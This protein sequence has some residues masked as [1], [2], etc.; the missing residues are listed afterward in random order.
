MATDKYEVI[1][2]LCGDPVKD[3]EYGTLWQEWGT[4]Q[5]GNNPIARPALYV[6]CIRCMIDM[7]GG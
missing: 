7:E 2:K 1:C 5:S 6:H 3:D 4:V